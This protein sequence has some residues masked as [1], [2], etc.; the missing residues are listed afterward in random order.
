[1]NL[2]SN[3]LL[4]SWYVTLYFTRFFYHLIQKP[5]YF[6]SNLEYN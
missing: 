6:L 3:S 1:M 4:G 2:E 5:T